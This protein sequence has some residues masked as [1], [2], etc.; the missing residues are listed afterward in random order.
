MRFLI[1]CFFSLTALLP[2]QMARS[3]PSDAPRTRVIVLG[4]DHGTQLLSERDQPGM[5]AAY[6]KQVQPDAICIERPPEQAARGDYYEY[7]YEVQGI[8]LPYAK[9]SRTTL[10]PIDWMPPVE[11]AKLGF[12]LD[13]DTP[14]EIR[15]PSGFQGFLTFPDRASL[16]RD[17]FAADDPQNLAAVVHWAATP[18]PRADLDLPRRLYLYRTFLQARRIHAAAIAHPGKTVLVVVGYFHKP[19]LEDILSHDPAIELVKASAYA[20]PDDDAVEAAT[21]TEHLA[22]ILSFN[23]LGAQAETG[24]VNWRWVGNVLDRFQARQQ[25]PEANLLRIR[26]EL[27]TGRIT[28]AQASR[29][30]RLLA[31]GTADDVRF[32]W[33]GVQDALRIDSFF[34]P[35]GNLS[36][37]QRALI[38]LAR[39]LFATGHAR[40]ADA[41]IGQVKRTLS[42]RQALQ[43][44]GYAERLRPDK[45]P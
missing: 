44:T 9:A 4:V 14:L 5:L 6:L 29:Q 33:T 16:T 30:F 18:A 2:L 36:V 32:S 15:R 34:D 10:C 35:F 28:P 7:T 25:G 31:A 24:I 23:L 37:R 8:I 39:C 1:A 41:T 26:Y 40:E 42:P 22:A 11:D 3:A 43:L 20:R 21:T 38:E 12:G 27:L 45:A 13:L 17:F 19:D